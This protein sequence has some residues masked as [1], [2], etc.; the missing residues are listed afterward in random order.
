MPGP[1]ERIVID[2]AGMRALVDALTAVRD[3][4]WAEAGLLV[5][6]MDSVSLPAG[7]ANRLRLL[8]DWADRSLEM[9]RRRL[10]LAEAVE[11]AELFAD[12]MAGLALHTGLGTGPGFGLGAGRDG[13]DGGAV[14][15]TVTA[16]G[17]VILR[18]RDVFATSAEARQAGRELAERLLRP[19]PD[20]Q[21]PTRIADALT[22]L[23]SHVYD[24]DFVVGFHDRLGPAGLAHILYRIAGLRSGLN[25]RAPVKPV[26]ASPRER[27]AGERIL[28]RSLALYSRLRD[29]GDSWLGRFNTRH[30]ADMA[31]TALLAPLLPHGRFGSG[32][33]ARLG[34]FL[35]GT[36]TSS[37]KDVELLA[38]PRPWAT[39]EETARHSRATYATTL[40]RSIAADPRLATRFASEHLRQIVHGSQRGQLDLPLRVGHPP[41]LE[42]ALAQLV[43]AA[44]GPAAREADPA[45]A[46][47]FVARLAETVAES[48]S[49]PVSP[50]LGVAFAQVLHTWRD[51]L[52]GAVITLLP[53]S[54]DDRTAPGL[55]IPIAQWAALLHQSLRGGASAPLLAA[56]AVMFAERLEEATWA[57]TRG[58]N[59]D[60]TSHYPTS[61]RA[62]AHL[63]ISQVN[64]FIS[65]ALIN[66]AEA[67]LHEHDLALTTHR[68]QVNAVVGV[69]VEVAG[70]LKA[71]DPAAFL[72]NLLI[73]P[74]LSLLATMARHSGESIPTDRAQAVLDDLRAGARLAPGWQEAYRSSAHDLWARRHDDPIRPVRVV[75]Q[76]GRT[77]V[78]TGDPR[79]D[80]FITG[81]ADDFLDA[82]GRPRDPETMTPAQR[83][84]YAAWLASPAMVANNDRIPAATVL[85]PQEPVPG[86]APDWARK[87][88]RPHPY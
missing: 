86:W 9:L 42:P 4:L 76:D 74:P 16:D 54:P 57:R 63:Q 25:P 29:L 37:I 85:L 20:G 75:D 21:D 7:P 30:R 38:A 26:F 28:G 35:F 41:E 52:Y 47:V 59:A 15:G 44:G 31:E 87:N 13:D 64:A 32:L 3:T 72:R 22:V 46:R 5:A 45:A 43:A 66:A 18:L 17:D 71:S 68:R 83:A 49:L 1:T 23:R 55:G 14:T 58:Y 6:Q 19:D 2:P 48:G 36:S 79:A 67:V 80:G 50:H 78:F 70:G 39:D 11:A 40:L 12:D 65:H 77:R 81:P 60:G 10:A 27:A 8:G 88:D 82:S 34:A 62:L 51:D 56:D 53:P 61:P 24:P 73:G 84:A 69:L 33:L